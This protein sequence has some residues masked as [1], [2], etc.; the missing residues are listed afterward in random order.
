MFAPETHPREGALNG[1]ASFNEAGAC[2]PRKRERYPLTEGQRYCFNEAGACL[3]RKPRSSHRPARRPSWRFN[4][5]GACLPRKPR[6]IR[7]IVVSILFV[8]Q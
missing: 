3:P 6:V 2:L 4:E 7:S 8:L 1:H 5:A